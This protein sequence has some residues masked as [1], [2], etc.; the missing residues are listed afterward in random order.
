MDLRQLTV[1]VA[2]AEH[3]S[4]SAAADALATVQSNVSTHIKKLET[5]LDCVLV[6]RATGELTEVGVLAVER[7]RRVI[8]ELDA[9]SSDVTAL[10]R[11]VVGTVQLGIIGTAA[12]WIV[13]QLLELLPTMHPHLHLS[14]REATTLGLD[15]E[16]ARGEIELAVLALVPAGSEIHT[17]ALFEEDLGLFLPRSHPLADRPSLTVAD[18]ATLALLLPLVGTNFRASLDDV[19][20]AADV[21]LEPRAE[22]DSLRLARSLMF[23]GCGFAILPESALPTRRKKTW[24]VV[25]IEGLQPRVIGVAQR[26]RALPGAPVRAVLE[27]LNAIVDDPK[28]LPSGVRAIA[29]EQR[30]RPAERRAPPRRAPYFPPGV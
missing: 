18:L 22:V 17:E 26:R 30:S 5:E 3:G 13:P 16:L 10:S 6:D 9:L 14:F 11:E 27:M 28:R 12:L 25:P 15:A 19:A 1:L 20:A 2:I 24:V 21:T 29:R 23:E 8:D 7:A 4:F